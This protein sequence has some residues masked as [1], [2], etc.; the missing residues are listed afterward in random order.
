MV[1]NNKNDQGFALFMAIIIVSVVI[2]IGLSILDLTMKQLRLSTNSKDSETAFHAANAG[3]ECARYY[4]EENMDEMERGDD[5]S[6][7][8]FGVDMTADT[9]H[10]SVAVVANG[11]AYLYEMEATW[12]SGSTERCSKMKT[13]VFVSEINTDTTIA[14]MNSAGLFGGGYPYGPTKTCE[15]GGRCAV[16]SS[17]GYS[18]GCND[19]LEIGT[20]QREVLLE[21]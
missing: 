3:L 5:I 18:K 7:S 1:T 8:C 17:Q 15:P 11:E 14:N 20:V 4:R 12:G 16:I 6:P 13:L 21:L 2:S 9:T 19:I 10:S